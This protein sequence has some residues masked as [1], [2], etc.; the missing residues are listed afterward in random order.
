MFY[1]EII[2][3]VSLLIV[4]III[5]QIIRVYRKKLRTILINKYRNIHN[6]S[7]QLQENLYKQSIL[8][9]SVNEY[10][11]FLK[12]VNEAHRK[13]L[14]KANTLIKNSGLIIGYRKANKIL[15]E[16]K[17]FLINITQELSSK[18]LTL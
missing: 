14:P 7:L 16:H 9:N 8:N 11:Y 5:Y 6:T 17:S 12:V 3:G 10:E 4:L 18:G 15:N 1:T 13:D 2:I